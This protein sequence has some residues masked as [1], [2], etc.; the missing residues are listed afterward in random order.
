MSIAADHALKARA[1]M[2]AATLHREESQ[3]CEAIDRGR[4]LDM[5]NEAL[6]FAEVHAQIAQA[7]AAIGK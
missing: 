2:T 7:Y 6:R 3:Q 5:M 4:R 1:Y